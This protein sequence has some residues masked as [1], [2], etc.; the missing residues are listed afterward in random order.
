M[1][2]SGGASDYENA[3]SGIGEI[4]TLSTKGFILS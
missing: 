4:L 1:R 3:S 2:V